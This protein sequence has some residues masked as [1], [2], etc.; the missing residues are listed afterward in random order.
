M[1]A[2]NGDGTLHSNVGWNHQWTLTGAG[3]SLMNNKLVWLQSN[4]PYYIQRGTEAQRNWADTT[5]I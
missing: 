3:E 2:N 4:S 1:L 5:S